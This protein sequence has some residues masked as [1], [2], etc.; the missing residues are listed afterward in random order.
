MP[1]CLTVQQAVRVSEQ[2]STNQQ[3]LQTA[4]A[5]ATDAETGRQTSC[6]VEPC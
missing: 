4:I 5:L 3:T 1:K 2:T 6:S